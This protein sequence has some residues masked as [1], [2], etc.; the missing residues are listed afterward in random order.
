MWGR[1]R[2]G[3]QITEKG[4]KGGGLKPAPNRRLATGE[5]WVDLEEGKEVPLI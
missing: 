1:E 4:G 5:A 2:I 3:H